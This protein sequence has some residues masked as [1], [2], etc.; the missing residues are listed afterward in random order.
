MKKMI[1][2]I[3][4]IALI[5]IGAEYFQ[6]VQREDQNMPV[7]TEF[8]LHKEKR[9]EFKK[10]RQEWM[11]QMHRTAPDTDWRKMDET[12]RR[13]KRLFKTQTREQILSDRTNAPSSTPAS[14]GSREVSGMWT[15]KGSNNLSGRIHTADIDFENGFI[16]C[17]SS[18][19]N[20]W[21]GT[22]NGEGWQSLNDYFQIPGMTLLRLIDTDIG[23]RLLIGA[24][25]TLYTTENDG[26]TIEE[27]T[28]LDN[29]QN[30]GNAKRIVVKNDELN[31]IYLL[32]KEWD[33]SLWQEMYVLHKSTDGGISFQQVINLSST[34]TGSFD[35]WT[36]RYTTSAVYLLNDGDLYRIQT[37]DQL[38][39]IAEFNPESTGNT[40]LT[41]GVQNDDVFLYARVGDH[42]YYSGNGG[43]TWVDKG[44]TPSGTFSVNSFNSS[45]NNPDHVYIGGMEVF[46]S[47]DGANSWELV[48]SWWEYY[49]NESDR[50]HADIPEIRL[51]PD[52]NGNE[53]TLISTDG[54][55]YASYDYLQS[56]SNLSLQG[57]G[58]SQYYG[59]YTHRSEPHIVYAGSQD[60][61]YQRS[62]NDG[63]GI[64]DFDQV[65][66][67]DY[68]H[69]VSSNGGGSIW[70]DYPGFVLYYPNALTNSN[71]PT[72]D[73]TGTSFLWLPPVTADPQSPH[74]AYAIGQHIV[75]LTGTNFS[76]THTVMPTQF[77]TD[78][79]YGSAMEISP[80]DPNYWYLLTT[81]GKFFHSEDG[82]DS[83]EQSV[84]FTLPGSHYFY[85]ATILASGV[86]LGRVI[87]A[88]SGYS[89]PAVF[90]T[91]DHGGSFSSMNTG[92]PSTLVYELAATENEDILFAATEVGPYAYVWDEGTWYDMAGISAPD[93]TY[94]TVDFVPELATAR[95]GTYG[96]GIWDFTLDNNY[97]IVPG[98]VNQDAIINVMDIILVVNFILEN[99]DPTPEQL[100]AA[101]L[102]GDGAVNIQDIIMI[103]NIILNI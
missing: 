16:Y 35:I 61:G 78:D 66:S 8:Q 41:G 58:V 50:L 2:L 81:D 76:V 37:N 25:K 5:Y 64:L 86:E 1:L 32:A 14:F 10:K 17:G 68:G 13:Q 30:W 9:K 94:W 96:R 45:N 79:N 31:T 93:Q 11:E 63:E 60:Q 44:Q 97:W 83:W 101:D 65:I 46:R 95:F 47:N 40:L 29:L 36:S 26:F 74:V 34:M 51:F 38:T 70:C 69:L 62:L 91:E 92:L 18:G 42:I 28:G 103:V 80:I 12:T 71:G 72:W 43:I 100:I 20:I 27:T 22:L 19:G 23:Q 88:G 77:A 89:N 4:L 6:S 59:T 49:G 82:G 67:G 75:R 98:D 84:G 53:L 24:G 56:V 102:N 15:E 57:L 55:L 39:F 48:N 90:M 54:G 85:G 99:A 52:L 87:V 21:K 33:Y 3:S 73:F 7:P